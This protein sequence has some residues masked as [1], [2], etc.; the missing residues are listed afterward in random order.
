MPFYLEYWIEPGYPVD[1]GT[2]TFFRANVKKQK[3]KSHRQKDEGGENG[4]ID[5]T[6]VWSSELSINNFSFV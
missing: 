6:N 2:I 1:K 5:N 3:K 4:D